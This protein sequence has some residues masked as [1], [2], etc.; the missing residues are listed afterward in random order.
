ML[1]LAAISLSAQP[2][3][4][5][6]QQLTPEQRAKQATERLT[7]E[8]GLDE[9]QQKQVYE[10]QLEMSKNFTRPAEGERPSREEMQAQ[11]EKSREK[12]KAEMKKI[13]TAEQFAKWE[14]MQAER[15]GAMMRGGNEGRQRPR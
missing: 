3:Q 14:K 10:C 2:P 6:R 7:K 9:A 13:L 12:Q 1:A 11:F 8:L 15:G 4:Q 5:Q